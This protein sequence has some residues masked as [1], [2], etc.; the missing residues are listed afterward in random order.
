MCKFCLILRLPK[1]L[2][3]IPTL[4][5]MY[6]IEFKLIYAVVFKLA[7]LIN[8]CLS[9]SL[10]EVIERYE[11]LL[12]GQCLNVVGD[13]LTI[14]L[15]EMCLSRFNSYFLFLITR[16]FDVYS[17]FWLW[18]HVWRPSLIYLNILQTVQDTQSFIHVHFSR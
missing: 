2:F 15:S 17:F 10:L 11:S 1:I 7:R 18:D 3:P 14:L 8:V 9:L 4:F 5:L 12:I 13:V 16:C 6:L